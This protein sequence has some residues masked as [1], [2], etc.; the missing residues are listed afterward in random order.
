M[1]LSITAALAAGLP[2]HRAH[3][4]SHQVVR[5]AMGDGVTLHTE[6]FLP[7]GEGPFPVVLIRAPYKMDP[8]L[9][10]RCRKLNRSGYGCVWQMVRGREDS[11][12]DWL[13]LENEPADGL[14]T[15]DWL[16]A[17]TWCDGNIA[18]MGE[19]YLGA[20]QWAV[21]AE[22]P[23]E[24]KTLIPMVIGASLYDAIYENGMFRHEIITAWMSLMPPDA[25]RLFSGAKHYRQALAHRPR[26]EMDLV[27]TGQTLPWFQDWVAADTP[28]A[29]YWNQPITLAAEAA[30]E[31]TEVPVLMI[32]GWADV[33][34]GPQLDT[35][36]HLASQER[37][38][39]VI[40]P[41]DHMGAVATTVRQ[42]GVDDDVGL[43][44]HYLQWTRI[45][46]WLDHHLRGAPLQYPVGAAIDYVEDLPGAQ[47]VIR[48]PNATTTCGCGS[49][50]SP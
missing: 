3:P 39:L 43:D 28:E 8:V 26:N 40:G 10:A 37:S 9:N 33:F 25:F 18:M 45:I 34:L 12:G 29:P 6:V 50:F 17:Q 22:L 36:Q 19:S 24:V 5:V 4:G 30:P 44:N 7:Q 41:W 20:V 31:H 16:I 11:G 48:N 42:R 38:T 21:A 47:F 23:P 46:D 14:T 32:G 13:P 15:L 49:S 35:W 1:L 2:D 27:S